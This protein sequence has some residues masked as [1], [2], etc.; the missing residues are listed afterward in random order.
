MS[1]EQLVREHF[2]ASAAMA[3]AT[4]E[5]ISNRIAKASALAIEIL[6]AG[7]KILICGNG[8]SASDAQHF[9]AELVCRYERERQP[10]AAIALTT[11]TAV[12]TATGNDYDFAQIFS[13]QIRALGCT[14]DLLV[15]ITTS[16]NS[17]NVIQAVE[18]AIE[19]KMH[20]VAL[21][22]K[23]GGQLALTMENS[24]LELRIPSAVTARIQEAHAIIIHSIC[25]LIE[26]HVTRIPPAT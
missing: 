12:L 20:V 5:I 10:L 4:S 19:K 6:E 1:P 2:K 26:L 11:D 15:A 22:G 14:G 21:T 18:S 9:A 25:N 7:G 17:D 24:E 23:D 3:I 16:G 13:R 8:G